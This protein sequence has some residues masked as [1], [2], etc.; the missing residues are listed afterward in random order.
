MLGIPVKT[1]CTN[2]NSAPSKGVL[3]QV[4]PD[5]LQVIHD[6]QTKGRNVSVNFGSTRT[7][8]EL[9]YVINVVKNGK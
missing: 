5:M 7:Q 8:V 6:R 9:Q 4:E 1:L 2:Q 3:L